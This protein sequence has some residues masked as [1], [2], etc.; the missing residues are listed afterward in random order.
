MNFST[1]KIIYIITTIITLLLIGRVYIWL[2]ATPTQNPS[3]AKGVSAPLYE[4]PLSKHM[5]CEKSNIYMGYKKDF[6]P[7]QFVNI[8][9]NLIISAK[10]GFTYNVGGKEYPLPASAV[11][12]TASCTAQAVSATPGEWRYLLYVHHLG[13]P[14]INTVQLK[15]QLSTCLRLAIYEKRKDI[16]PAYSKR[17]MSKIVEFLNKTYNYNNSNP[18]SINMSKYFKNNQNKGVAPA[19]S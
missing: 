8:I 14:I 12:Y 9:N 7:K 19:A 15:Y 1:K 6:P 17:K 10:K 3:T 16:N 11:D 5:L 2:T 13:A 4:C 18:L